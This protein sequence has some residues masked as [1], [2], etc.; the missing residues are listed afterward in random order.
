MY[1]GNDPHARIPFLEISDKKHDQIMA[2]MQ[3]LPL[4]HWVTTGCSFQSVGTI[5]I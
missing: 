1:N 5:Q 2:L 4:V 3:L